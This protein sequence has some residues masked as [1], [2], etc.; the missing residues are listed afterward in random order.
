MLSEKDEQDDC[1]PSY[2]CARFRVNYPNGFRDWRCW[3]SRA[4]FSI[5]SLLLLPRGKLGLNLPIHSGQS[6]G[7][8][9]PVIVHCRPLGECK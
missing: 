6:V 5:S 7:V 3:K 9:R 4:P 1:C 8:F 2:G